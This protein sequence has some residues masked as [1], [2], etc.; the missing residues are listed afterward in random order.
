MKKT[1]KALTLGDLILAV[2]SNARSTRETMAAVADLLGS[3]RCRVAES[4]IDKSLLLPRETIHSLLGT[5]ESKRGGSINRGKVR[6]F[7]IIIGIG[8]N[9]HCAHAGNFVVCHD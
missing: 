8:V 4:R 2:S 1:S 5:A 6:V 9:G 3:G 7:R